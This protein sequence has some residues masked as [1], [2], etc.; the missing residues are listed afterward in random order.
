MVNAYKITTLNPF[1]QGYKIISNRTNH[2]FEYGFSV[3]ILQKRLK[4]LSI[5]GRAR[6]L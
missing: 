1:Q 3:S 2:Y 4:T 6:R 5:F